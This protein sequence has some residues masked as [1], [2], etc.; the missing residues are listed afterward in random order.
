MA[1]A[2]SA[3]NPSPRPTSADV[4]AGTQR[5]REIGRAAA[6]HAGNAAALLRLAASERER[7]TR[8]R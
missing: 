7:S 2:S 3:A 6:N 8:R 4:R 5:I 1:T